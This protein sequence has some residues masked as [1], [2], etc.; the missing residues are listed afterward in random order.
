MEDGRE[1]REKSIEEEKGRCWEDVKGCYDYKQA[2]E[3]YNLRLRLM[4]DLMPVVSPPYAALSLLSCSE[5]QRLQGVTEQEHLLAVEGRALLRLGLLELSSVLDPGDQTFSAHFQNIPSCYL[6]FFLSF[7]RCGTSPRL[8][9]MTR[10]ACRFDP[11]STFSSS[12]YVAWTASQ[13][14]TRDEAAL[15]L[16][17][18]LPCLLLLGFFLRGLDGHVVIVVVGIVAA[19]LPLL[20]VVCALR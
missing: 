10:P 20:V 5:C 6:G 1:R 12:R 15:Y 18:D 7:E 9:V 2:S 17:D 14:T 3:G 8:A 19:L 13:G 11:T 16:L 4:F